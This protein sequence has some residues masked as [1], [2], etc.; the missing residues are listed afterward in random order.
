[1]TTTEPED[2]DSAEPATPEGTEQQSQESK[3]PARQLRP[4]PNV[5]RN[6]EQELRDGT[7][8]GWESLSHPNSSPSDAQSK[9]WTTPHNVRQLAS[10]A[11]KVATMVLNGDMDPETA[12]TYSALIRT[13]AQSMSTEVTRAR[14]QKNVPDL[15][16]EEVE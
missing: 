7:K 11:N 12:R 9:P 13:V 1:V 8:S 16:F 10:Q 5:I 15:T 4:G 6:D 3:R 14:S 2:Q